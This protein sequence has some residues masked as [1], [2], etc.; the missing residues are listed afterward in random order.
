[1]EGP[2]YSEVGTTSEHR[3]KLTKSEIKSKQSDGR[4]YIIYSSVEFTLIGTK[5]FISQHT[6]EINYKLA[7]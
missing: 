2:R 3:R 7:L 5:I 6:D 1:M 4:S